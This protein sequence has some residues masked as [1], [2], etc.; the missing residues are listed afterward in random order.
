MPRMMN[1]TSTELRVVL[2]LVLVL[3]MM[4]PITAGCLSDGEPR[5]LSDWYVAMTIERFETNGE[6]AVNVTELLFKVRFGNV[7]KDTWMLQESSGFH[8]GEGDFFPIRIEA[9]YDDGK[10]PVEDFPILGTS[11]VVTGAMRFDGDEM[12]FEFDGDKALI[13]KDR[14]I[15]RYPHDYE[16][17]VK[18]TGEYGELTLYFNLNEPS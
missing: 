12:R 8:K 17:T 15:D 18:L 2:P 7:T 9:R 4:V 11:H 13:S 6:R 10:N 14:S 1:D 16:R 3:M 5:D